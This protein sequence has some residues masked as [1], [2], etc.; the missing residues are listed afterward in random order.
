MLG[1][2]EQRPLPMLPLRLV[3][4]PERLRRSLYEAFHLQVRYHRPSHEVTIRV[5]VRAETLAAITNTVK[6]V[7]DHE[8][9]DGRSHVLCAPSSV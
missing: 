5:T 7:S 6:E 8:I 9:T 4:A 2:K 3:D 1:A